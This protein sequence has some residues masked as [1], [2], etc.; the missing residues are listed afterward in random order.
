MAYSELRHVFRKT[1]LC[2]QSGEDEQSK[3]SNPPGEEEWEEVQ[4]D[5]QA[6]KQTP[7]SKGPKLEAGKDKEAKSRDWD[8][9]PTRQS[10]EKEKERRAV[11]ARMCNYGSRIRYPLHKL[12]IRRSNILSQ[13]PECF[14]LQRGKIPVCRGCF[15]TLT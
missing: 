9:A 6:V 13:I 15:F 14:I 3:S 10:E 11:R 8:T 2:R 1:G 5:E 7:L 4:A 12:T